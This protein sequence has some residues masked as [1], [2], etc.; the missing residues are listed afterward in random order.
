MKTTRAS[1]LLRVRD[2]ADAGAWAEFVGLYR[3]LLMRY[4]RARGLGVEDGE[5]V[6]QHC[7]TAITRK[8]SD[9]EYDPLKGRFR[10]WLKKMVN[11]R[12]ANL[13]R[14]R[15]AINAG[16]AEFQRPQE[17][18]AGPEEVWEKVWLEEH[19][20]F[21]CDQV[22]NEVQPHTYEAFRRVAIEQQPVVEVCEA[23]GLTANQVYVA[24]S[25]V[26]R[27]LQDMMKTIYGDD[28]QAVAAAG[29]ACARRCQGQ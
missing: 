18:E 12:V 15:R 11:D 22:N 21:C 26:T 9:F 8:I 28:S 27:R 16:S 24:K 6:A 1:L 2:H 3:P 19:L 4:A 5:D 29:R 17:R 25:R 13:L 20:R 23:L 7:L 10:G 14:R